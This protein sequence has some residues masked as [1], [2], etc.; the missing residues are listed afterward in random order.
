MQRFP[1]KRVFITGAGSGFGKALSLEF[2]SRGW[3]V[4][5]SDII[6]ERVRQTAEEV[7]RK[8]GQA[9]EIVCDVTKYG[10]LEKAAECLQ[11]EWKGLDIV[12]NNA[13][14]AV[15]GQMEKVAVDDW[16]KV[17]DVDLKSVIYGCRIFIPMFKRQGQGHIVNM[18]SAAGFVALPEMGPY[19]V[20]KAGVIALSETI[21]LELAKHNIGVTVLMPTFFR[22]NLTEKAIATEDRNLQWGQKMVNEAKYTSEQ[23]VRKT[24]I[25]IEKNCLY[26]VPQFDAREFW[27]LKRHTPNVYNKLVGFMY[28][29]GLDKFKGLNP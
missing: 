15:V 26:V 10:E 19:N 29:H 4:G 13:G 23:V 25:A 17:I 6:E 16:D 21:R 18:A 14:I 1:N 27:F 9:L 12:V 11:Q 7:R 5:V 28:K 22:T 8:G 20:A 24:M 2:A 3:K